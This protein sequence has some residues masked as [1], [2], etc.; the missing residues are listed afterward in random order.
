MKNLRWRDIM[1]A[2]DREGREIVV[3]FVQGKGGKSPCTKPP[4]A[5]VF[6][7]L[8]PFQYWVVQSAW[9]KYSFRAGW[10]HRL[11]AGHWRSTGRAGQL[12]HRAGCLHSRRAVGDGGTH[13]GESGDRGR[14]G[15]GAAAGQSV[16]HRLARQ[17]KKLSPAGAQPEGGAS[18]Y[19]ARLDV[20]GAFGIGF[21]GHGDAA[22]PAAAVAG[23]IVVACTARAGLALSWYDG[24]SRGVAQPSS[25]SALGAEGREFESLRP[26][27]SA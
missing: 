12:H 24:G 21:G 23:R 3:M 17:P 7:H 14:S 2:K 20:H 15:D 11:C 26:D 10:H 1:P 18:R 6:V 16:R 19:M 27:H 4:L 25:A 22:A 9:D 8:Q 13:G 5:A